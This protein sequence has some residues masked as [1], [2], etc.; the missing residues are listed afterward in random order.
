MEVTGTVK[1]KAIYSDSNR[2]YRYYLEKS[3]VEKAKQGEKV[4]TII[5]LNPSYADE[6]KLDLS[7]MKVF[8]MLL[9]E[10]YTTLKVVNLFAF[11]ATKH[12]ALVSTVANTEEENDNWIKKAITNIDLL[13]IAWGSNKDDYKRRKYKVNEI[14]NGIDVE[15]KPK[16]IK[17]FKDKENRKCRHPSRLGKL[18]LIDYP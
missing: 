8:N 12:S 3:A 16:Q 11:V 10:G 15:E 2:C 14:I 18:E 9:K 4:A 17:C 6:Y 1:T 5:M 7:I 13:I